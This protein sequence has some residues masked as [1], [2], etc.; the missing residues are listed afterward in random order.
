[1]ANYISRERLIDLTS[2]KRFQ[3]E[4]EFEEF[5]TPKIVDLFMIENSQIVNQE[6]TTTFDYTLSNCADIVIKSKGEFSRIL[7][8]I[9]LKL[10][11]NINKYNN[12]DWTN[13]SKQLHKYCQDVRAPYG[14]VLSEDKCLIYHYK[15]YREQ[16]GYNDHPD[17]IPS[18]RRIEEEVV[19]SLF[20]EAIVH[21]KSLK[22]IYIVV[23]AS[24]IFS[25]LGYSAGLYIQK[26][27]SVV[28]QALIGVVTLISSIVILVNFIKKEREL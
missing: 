8:V 7:V 25:G 20:I 5:I 3:T 27:M 4:K 28:F 19:Q 9:E 14:I 17:K 2:G 6:T 26:N 23:F 22:Y 13:A 15:W 24:V 1:M 16:T 11:R 21:E 18:I 10:E 12:T